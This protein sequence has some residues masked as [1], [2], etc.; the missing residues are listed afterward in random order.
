MIERLH[1][2][3]GIG[4]S[5]VEIALGEAVDHRLAEARLVVEHVMRNADRLRH[6]AG[7]VDVLAG[8]A[9]A[10]AMG[11]GAVVVELERDA[12]DI[13]ALA[14]EQGCD[15]GRIHAARHGDDDAGLR[16]IGGK[17]E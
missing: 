3:Q 6:A 8:A 1:S 7:I 2:T 17:V 4:V 9:G 13:V 16:G 14:L 10:F 15:D 12:D 5:P 11:G